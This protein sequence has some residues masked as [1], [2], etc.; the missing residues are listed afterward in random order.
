[1]STRER[2][3]QVRLAAAA[4]ADFRDIVEWTAE[5]FGPRQAEVY[6]RT[7]SAAIAA[8]TAGPTIVGAKA[9]ADI[10]DGVFTLHVARGRRKGRHFI[11]FRATHD[12]A[13]SV[14]DV[15]RV[16]HDMMDLPRHVEPGDENP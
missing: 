15:L 12:E 1:M 11:L 7:I 13:T 4:E 6:A 9:R 5:Q 16:L 3:W 14:V 8:L 2:A 10:A